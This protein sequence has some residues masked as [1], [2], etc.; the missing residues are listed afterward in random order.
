MSSHD[1]LVV[2]DSIFQVQVLHKLWLVHL[3]QVLNSKLID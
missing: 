2:F 3:K 1:E